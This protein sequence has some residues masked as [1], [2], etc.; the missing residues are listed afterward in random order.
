M[1]AITLDLLIE[2]C[3]AGGPSCLTSRTELRPAGGHDAAVAPAKFAADRVDGGTYAYERRYLDSEIRDVVIIDSKQSQL[4]RTEAAISAS[5]EDGHPL[6][7]RIPRVEVTYE[8]DG[9]TEKYSDLTL[10]HRVYDG[11][12]RAGNIG[13]KPATQTDKY[14]AV[15][16]AT[17]GNARAMLEVSPVTLIFGGWDAS[18]RSR[19]GRWRSILVGE[20]IGFCAGTDTSKRGGAR[21]D[22]VAMS[23]QLGEKALRAIT[24]EQ[25]DE[26]SDKTK[27]SLAITLKKA[28]KEPQSASALG[29]GGIPPALK[30]LAGVACDPITRSHVLSFASLR[31]IRFG[32]GVEGDVACRALLAALALNGLARSDAEL[33][34]R[35]NCD[36]VESGPAVVTIDRRYGRT[37]DLDSLSIDDADALLDAAL[38]HAQS[39][40]G[41]EWNGTSMVVVGNPDVVAGAVDDTEAEA[42]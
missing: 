33:Y 18:R 10:P 4:N 19:Q 40:A 27:K 14:R 12:I 21:V 35:A 39:T 22:P 8:R 3:S 13:G 20:I 16:N 11:H 25:H 6:L 41:V 15:R 34:L 29:L 9:E 23:I 5:V 28:A 32:A 1:T 38:T 26:L 2:A 7:S 42:K 31:Q 36:L 37:E 30:Q 24:E 17:P